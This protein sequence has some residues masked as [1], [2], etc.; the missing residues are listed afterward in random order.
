MLL[1]PLLLLSLP[2]ATPLPAPVEQALRA[3]AAPGVR[4]QASGF[5]LPAA[6]TCAVEEAQA[7]H[8]L[9]RS[10]P[11]ALHVRGHLPNGET[12]SGTGWASVRAFGNLLILSVP[13]A[14]GGALEHAARLEERELTRLQPAVAELPSGAVAS[15]AL[16]AGSALSRFDVREA[17]PNPGAMVTVVLHHGALSLSQEG[18]AVPCSRGHACALL[19]SGRRVEG[20]WLDGRIV[21]EVP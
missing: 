16:A 1:L 17:G 9:T 2:G 6:P 15:R 14:A 19:P 20:A 21:W 8:T 3:A 12:C 11:V 10:E 13:V 18:R 7:D 5:R 4:I